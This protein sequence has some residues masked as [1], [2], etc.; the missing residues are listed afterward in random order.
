MAKK[1]LPKL[2][3][4]ER[5][6]FD[7]AVLVGKATVRGMRISVEQILRALAKGGSFDA[8]LDDYPVL[9]REDIQAC[10]QYAADVV[11]EKASIRLQAK[12]VLRSNSRRPKEIAERQPTITDSQS[13]LA[14]R[15]N[16]L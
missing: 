5:I 13:P 16:S 2:K 12:T 3:I 7:P 15:K 4:E 8:I 10:L 6:S 9:E 11:A 14:P 1:Q